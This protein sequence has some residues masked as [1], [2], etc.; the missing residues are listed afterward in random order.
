MS[1]WRG[2]CHE[3]GSNPGRCCCSL[4][5]GTLA[6]KGLRINVSLTWPFVTKWVVVTQGDVCCSL[7]RD[8]NLE[9]FEDQ[10]LFDVALV[11]KWVVTQGGVVSH[12]YGTALRIDVSLTWPLS[13]N[14]F[15][16]GGHCCSLWREKIAVRGWKGALS[17]LALLASQVGLFVGWPGRLLSSGWVLLC[18]RPTRR[19]LTQGVSLPLK[20]YAVLL[21]QA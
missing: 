14:G 7:W 18:G 10:C 19:G 5:R 6:W 16:P 1:L 2:L 12:S 4:W 9:G 8:S 11:T 17:D 21:R 15:S 3:M 13:R 20:P